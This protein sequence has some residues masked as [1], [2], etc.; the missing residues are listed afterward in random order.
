KKINKRLEHE[1][2]ER[3]S[4]IERDKL[5]L[6]RQA[7]RLEEQ[8]RQKAVF[9]TNVSHDLRTPLTLIDG[10]LEHILHKSTDPEILN[11]AQL[12][13]QNAKLTLR[14]IDQ[15]MALGR[16]EQFNDQAHLGNMDMGVFIKGLVL[17]FESLAQ[18]RQIRLLF[19]MDQSS[20]MMNCDPEIMEKVMYN[21]L[22]NAFKFTEHGG[23]V[24]VEIGLDGHIFFILVKDS[25][26]G[27][28]K[29]DL[30]FIFN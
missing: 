27:I 25:G 10:P 12:G 14:L 20:L 16:Q 5:L 17:S 24:Q 26:R 15:L 8:E 2:G 30:P 28:S 9:F 23:Q 6:E 1:V 18:K 3:T 21:L 7:L 13:L 29:K 22:S 4:Q 19:S 11:L